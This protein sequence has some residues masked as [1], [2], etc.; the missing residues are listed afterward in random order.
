M[1]VELLRQN[2]RKY[3]WILIVTPLLTFLPAEVFTFFCFIAATFGRLPEV[4][5]CGSRQC[6][7]KADAADPYEL[8]GYR[9][10]PYG[11]EHHDA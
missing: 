8:E 1:E 9:C 11:Q 3:L 10:C 7:L 4:L 2:R 6:R 5:H